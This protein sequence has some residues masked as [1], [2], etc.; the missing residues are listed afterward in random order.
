MIEK[1]GHQGEMDAVQYLLQQMKVE[2]IPCSEDLFISLIK[3]Y[4]RVGGSEQALKTFYRIREFGCDPTVR[5]YNHLLDALLCENRFRMITPLYGIMKKDGLEPNVYT[6]NILLKVLC[7]NNSF[8]G[9]R[10]L[11]EEMSIKG[12]E[13]D[14]VSYTTIVSFLCKDGKIEE[15]RHLVSKL[16]PCVPVYNV[17]IGGY[18]REL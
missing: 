7:K 9:A 17:L 15:A 13:P 3:S 1:L 18:C 8:S 2:G 5:I 16:I 4:S 10:R 12:C 11:L 6:Y 14:D